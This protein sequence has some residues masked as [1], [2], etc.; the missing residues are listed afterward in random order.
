MN[1]LLL[2]VQLL[3]MRYCNAIN[4]ISYIYFDTLNS[5]WHP[6]YSIITQEKHHLAIVCILFSFFKFVLVE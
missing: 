6:S 1:V 5:Y 3:I 4:I 2:Y